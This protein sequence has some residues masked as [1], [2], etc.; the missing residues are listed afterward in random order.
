MH[1]LLD[2]VGAALLWTL[3]MGLGRA[4][5]PEVKDAWATVYGLL[6]TTMKTA[7]RNA[8]AAA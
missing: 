5:T 1:A 4:F 8:L 6:A 7:A 2:T 3:E